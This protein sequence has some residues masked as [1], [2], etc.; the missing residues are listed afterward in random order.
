METWKDCISGTAGIDEC[1][2]DG[3]TYF[4]I[5]VIVWVKT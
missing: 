1:R 5:L 3:R 2:A 4:I